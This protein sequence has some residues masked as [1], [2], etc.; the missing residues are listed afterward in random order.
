M[1]KCGYA[2]KNGANGSV[3]QEIIMVQKPFLTKEEFLERIISKARRY[4]YT[5]EQMSMI[6]EILF[7]CRDL[8]KKEFGEVYDY[9]REY[10]NKTQKKSVHNASSILPFIK[11]NKAEKIKLYLMSKFMD[12]EFFSL[13]CQRFASNK[14]SNQRIIRFP[15]QETWSAALKRYLIYHLVK[16]KIKKQKVW[17]YEKEEF[18]NQKEREKKENIVKKSYQ[19]NRKQFE[20]QTLKEIGAHVGIKDP[21]EVKKKYYEAEKLFEQ[22]E[23]EAKNICLLQEIF[24]KELAKYQIEIDKCNI[25]IKKQTFTKPQYSRDSEDD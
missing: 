9:I 22:N 21:S 19:K 1:L 23:E 12:S 14:E 2:K 20:I 13:L 3:L 8:S 5:E 15:S 16:D 25:D 7:H 17:D 24:A 18:K 10:K 4:Y 6:D 11:I